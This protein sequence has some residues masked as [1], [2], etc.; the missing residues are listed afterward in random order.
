MSGGQGHVL[1]ALSNLD[2]GSGA[3]ALPEPIALW[4]TCTPFAARAGVEANIESCDPEAW[5]VRTASALPRTPCGSST[6]P[7]FP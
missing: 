3:G 6:G 7:V 1:Q 5:A 4:C 2:T